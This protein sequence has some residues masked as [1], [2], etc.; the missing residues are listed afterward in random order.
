MKKTIAILVVLGLHLNAQTPTPPI[1]PTPAAIMI[2]QPTINLS[3]IRISLSAAL[4]GS[5]GSTVFATLVAAGGVLPTLPTGQRMGRYLVTINDDG[6][7]NIIVN[8]KA[9]TSGT[10]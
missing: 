3:P 2:P 9:A 6:S 7:S 1:T 8:Y 5:I 10:N 4:T